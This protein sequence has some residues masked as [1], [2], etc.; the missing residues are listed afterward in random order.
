MDI[1]R[2][3]ST[4][5]NARH[6]VRFPEPSRETNWEYYDF[7]TSSWRPVKPIDLLPY[8][9]ISFRFV[10]GIEDT[11]QEVQNSCVVTC[12]DSYRLRRAD[13]L[14]DDGPF[15]SGGS[16]EVG[17]SHDELRDEYEWREDMVSKGTE[18][19][20][21]YVDSKRAYRAKI[22]WIKSDIV[23]GVITGGRRECPN[24]NGF[25]YV[26]KE[27]RRLVKPG[28]HFPKLTHEEL[29]REVDE[30]E[31]QR[32]KLKMKSEE[33]CKFKATL[34]YRCWSKYYRSEN[35]TFT[36]FYDTREYFKSLKGCPYPATKDKL[37]ELMEEHNIEIKPDVVTN[38][39][40]TVADLCLFLVHEQLGLGSD[41]VYGVFHATAP[42]DGQ[43]QTSPFMLRDYDFF[44]DI[45][46]FG[47]T[48]AKLWC[49]ATSP[50]DSDDGY[51]VGDHRRG[52]DL[53]PCVKLNP[54]GTNKAIIFTL[55]DVTKTNPLFRA[56]SGSELKI[57][58]D[59]SQ[60]EYAGGIM[61]GTFLVERV[62]SLNAHTVNEIQNHIL[63]NGHAWAPSY[64]FPVSELMDIPDDERPERET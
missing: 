40:S 47:G 52:F 36:R 4:T 56:L 21:E 5:I 62:C 54:D 55:H 35:K 39:K 46:V 9:L 58:T 25:G 42:T 63:L 6:A 61:N 14:Q 16:N 1:E 41:W 12:S 51:S 53:T 60:I 22:C 31:Q 64:A 2:Y 27:S 19:D 8:D 43:W 33:K 18:A 49:G 29:E 28:T 3:D 17:L 10:D 38:F 59:G 30:K 11:E 34:P 24:V 7:T 23:P 13:D 45:K 57:Y 15:G 50:N 48:Y 37:I 20:F 44:F 26:Y 32:Q